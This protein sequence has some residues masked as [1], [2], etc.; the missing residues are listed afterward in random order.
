MIRNFAINSQNRDF[1]AVFQPDLGS[2]GELLAPVLSGGVEWCEEVWLGSVV[3]RAWEVLGK[4]KIRKNE[5]MNPGD[6]SCR[7]IEP[8]S[9][10]SQS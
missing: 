5:Q 7:R 9:Q 10:R 6:S 3:S 2:L 8:G 1:G 4:C